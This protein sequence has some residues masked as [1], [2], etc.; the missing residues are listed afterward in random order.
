MAKKSQLT[1][2]KPRTMNQRSHSMNATKR[3]QGINL[4]TI[5]VEGKKI[6]ATAREIK[7]IKKMLAENI[8][9]SKIKKMYNKACVI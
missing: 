8:P 5:R 4:Q 6:C 3:V 1:G 9:F 2:K 7:A